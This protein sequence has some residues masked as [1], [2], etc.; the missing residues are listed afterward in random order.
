MVIRIQRVGEWEG[1]GEGG[2]EECDF[3]C[4]HTIHQNLLC[5]LLFH[6]LCGH[7][8]AEGRGVEG[9]GGGV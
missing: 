8:D 7:A 3:S 6:F 9:A 1:E 2:E 4:L 5:T